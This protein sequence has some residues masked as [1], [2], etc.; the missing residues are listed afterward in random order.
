MLLEIIK[1]RK[2]NVHNLKVTC[3]FSIGRK[4]E[5]NHQQLYEMK[6]KD[7]ICKIW[8]GEKKHRVRGL[9]IFLIRIPEKESG[10]KTL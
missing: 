10:E 4:S 3:R 7:T 6:R 5:L 8:R 9:N 2:C 1:S